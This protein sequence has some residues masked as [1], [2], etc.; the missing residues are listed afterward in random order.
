MSMDERS[1]QPLVFPHVDHFAAFF[2]ALH[3]LR[4]PSVK[5]FILNANSE[6]CVKRA[7]CDFKLLTAEEHN[8]ACDDCLKSAVCHTAALVPVRSYILHFKRQLDHSLHLLVLP[9]GSP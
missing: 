9:Q 2:T 1:E 5:A 6:V 3:S 4:C 8:A 7:P